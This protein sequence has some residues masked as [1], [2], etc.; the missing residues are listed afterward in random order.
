MRQYA[1]TERLLAIAKLV[2]KTPVAQ[3]ASLLDQM[4]NCPRELA[5]QAIN[6]MILAKWTAADP[7]AALAY[8]TIISLRSGDPAL[9]NS[10][11]TLW[12]ATDPKAAL[13]A[14]FALKNASFR[15]VGVN[16]V[17]AAWAEGK[18]PLGAVAAAKRLPPGQGKTDFLRMVFDHWGRLD[19]AAALA[20]LNQVDNPSTRQSLQNT[21]IGYLANS[22]PAEALKTLAGLPAGQQAPATYGNLFQKW[23]A[24][25]P[26][27]AFTA[28]QS[29]PAGAG[30]LA[31]IQSVFKSWA[32]TDPLAALQAAQSLPPNGERNQALAESVRAYVIK[33]H[34]A[35]ADYIADMAQGVSRD[36]LIGVLASVWANS[37]PAAT[38]A[39]L[40][41][42][43]DGTM[44]DTSVYSILGQM[45]QEHPLDALAYISRLPES[46]LR[47]K[48]VMGTLNGWAKGD[49]ASALAWA[50][51]NLT[52]DIYD[53]AL[54]SLLGQMV[55]AN[56]VDASVYIAQMPASSSRDDLILHVASSLAKQDFQS[57]INWAQGLAQD[58][59][60]S[61]RQKAW[62]QIIDTIAVKD[63]S[64]AAAYA[65][66]L[67]TDPNAR[68]AVIGVADDWAKSD[69]KAALAWTESLP[70][71]PTR[72]SAMAAAVAGFSHIDAVEAWNYAL[73][74]LPAGTPAT[75]AAQA[76]IAV[77]LSKTN[78]VAAAQAVMTLPPGNSRSFATPI[79]A[80]NLAQQDASA[81]A[82]FVESIPVGAER[83]S[84][85]QRVIPTQALNNG[86]AAYA[87]ALTS[88]TDD[89]RYITIGQAL[90]G[91]AVYDPVA[92]TTVLQ[93]AP[94]TY[95]QRI[96]V[97]S[98]I[99]NAKSIQAR[100]DARR[101]PPSQHP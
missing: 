95:G 5:R 3:L 60:D 83:D 19:P 11:F 71:G 84:V 17:L 33:D 90:T 8:A 81:A 31:A 36:H 21:I 88:S 74:N 57:A 14:A 53:S 41:Q 13:A 48:Y 86:A 79:I 46:A 76:E 37:D 64:S 91:W 28:L 75:K 51:T 23:G 9:L 92:A 72:D 56:P 34:Q 93:S 58:V 25:N 16:T 101:K 26:V 12:A 49:A 47:D 65:Q 69:S 94:L 97:Q 10:V 89:N 22:N 30:R 20:A 96:S 67:I 7:Q 45:A 68:A 54:A 15:I 77:F 59:P 62:R 6:D 78:P 43:A 70:P 63:P 98:Q 61:V 39:W 100:N 40:D 85:M 32:A 4:R 24:Q 82:K 52:G 35:A 2:E 73:N 80:D 99:S 18:D 1:G 87:L 55:N 50:N 42:N 27:E 38:L 66:S 44:H 29:I